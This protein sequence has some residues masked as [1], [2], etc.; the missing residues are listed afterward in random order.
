MSKKYTRFR[1][2]KTVARRYEDGVLGLPKSA[3]VMTN[4]ER[5]TAWCPRRWWYAVPNR[6]STGQTKAMRF[7]SLFHECLE[8]IYGWWRDTDKEFQFSFLEVCPYCDGKGHAQLDF[9]DGSPS[10]KAPCMKCEGT[11][12]GVL[13]LVQRQL[14]ES[15][16][17][18]DDP[19]PSDQEAEQL[20]RAVEGYL[21]YYG[22][23][24][25]DKFKILSVEA[26]IAAPVI[27]PR[28]AKVYKS[29]VPVVENEFGWQLADTSTHPT[30]VKWV[31]MP[32]YQ[33]GK[34]DAVLQDRST[35]NVWLG[36]FKTSA[37]P[38]GYG[39]DLHLDTQLPG[40]MR[41]LLHVIREHKPWGLSGNEDVSGYIWD[42]TSSQRQ[43]DPKRL[44]SGRV[45][46]DKRLRVPS[47]RVDPWIGKQEGLTHEDLAVLA[48]MKEHA[49]ESFDFKFFHREWGAWDHEIMEQYDLELFVEAERF[50]NFWKSAINAVHE[51]DVAMSFPRVPLC[52]SRG[53]FC[54]FTAICGAGGSEDH[55]MFEKRQP[56]VWL[57]KSG[58]NDMAHKENESCPF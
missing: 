43:S 1:A 23:K 33:I 15:L 14:Y 32:W 24:P 56:T 46:T 8:G 13:S 42:V 34:C 22:T 50:S 41:S 4:S 19:A 17:T 16:T 54:D 37:D 53:G 44:K 52:R 48:K 27:N 47:W 20:K 51:T 39:R 31:L 9:M 10:Y 25:S 26:S 38:I 18:F 3:M 30:E 2:A 5:R 7:G 6:L 57:S 58:I 11:G 49:K 28:T 12:M 36:E 29:R 35:G 55:S 40:Y 45:S 21:H